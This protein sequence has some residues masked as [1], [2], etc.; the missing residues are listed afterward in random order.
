MRQVA[1]AAPLAGVTVGAVPIIRDA[2]RTRVLLLSKR[3]DYA[4]EL[5]FSVVNLELGQRCD[6][7]HMPARN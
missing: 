7:D 6:R 5:A 1:A 2:A 4:I 3:L